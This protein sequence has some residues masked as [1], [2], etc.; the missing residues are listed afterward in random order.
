[1]LNGDGLDKRTSLYRELIEKE[2]ELVI[3]LGGDPSPPE[4][5]IVTDTIKELL[6]AA[7]LDH[8]LLSLKSLVH[9]GRVHGVLA[10]R[11][12]IGTHIREN[13]KTLGLKRV[14]KT[15]TLQQ[16]LEQENGQKHQPQ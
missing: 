12:R 1:M 16:L 3:A 4:R 15:L 2:Q 13:L 14:A 9:K 8:Y 11:T 10:E 6:S 7:F 5:T